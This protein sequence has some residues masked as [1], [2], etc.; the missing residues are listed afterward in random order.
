MSSC[1]LASIF[2]NLL[3]F[4]KYILVTCSSAYLAAAWSQSRELLLLLLSRYLW[5]AVFSCSYTANCSHCEARHQSINPPHTLASWGLTT[6]KQAVAR[7]LDS[8]VRR[9]QQPREQAFIETCD[10]LFSHNCL[11]CIYRE[12]QDQSYRH[13]IIILIHQSYC[14]FIDELTPRAGVFRRCLY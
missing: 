5:Y 11:Q 12:K 4:Y 1:C 14:I 8:P 3:T 9:K 6:S 2:H 10:A 7:Y 13:L